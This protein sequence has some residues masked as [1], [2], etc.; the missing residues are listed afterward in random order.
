MQRRNDS[1]QRGYGLGFEIRI[2]LARANLLLEGVWREGRLFFCVIG[3]FIGLSLLNLWSVVPSWLH[4]L[5]LVLFAVAA[6][7]GLYRAVRNF[8]LPDRARALAYL[9]RRNTLAHRP[10]RSLGAR[11]EAEATRDSSSGRLWRLYQR[12]LRR[13]VNG[14]KVGLP[15]LDMGAGDGYGVRALVILLLVA[16][17]IIAGPR[18]GERL[19]AALTPGIG[20]PAAPA[21]VTAWITPPAYTGQAPILLPVTGEDKGTPKTFVVPTNSN[22]IAHIFGGGSGI[23]VLVTDDLR[24]DFIAVDGRNFQ[25][26]TDF[27]SSRNVK[28]EKEGETVANWQ[29]TVIPDEAP[30]V[31]LISEP[32]V[33]ERSAFRLQYRAAD[34]YGVIRIGGEISRENTDEIMDI[35]LP[36]PGRGSKQVVS[37]SYHDLTAHPWAGLPVTLRL[38]AE[39][40][41]GQRGYSDAHNFTLPERTFTHPV[42]KVLIEQRKYLATDAEGNRNNAALVL[43][44]LAGLPESY[45]HDTTVMLSLTAARAILR[46]GTGQKSIDEASDILWET[47]LRLENGSLSLAEAALRA[48]QEALMEALNRDASD[49]EIARLVDEL[50]KAMENFL[51]ALAEQQPMDNQPP[52][53]PNSRDQI[54]RSQDLQQML[55]RIE[56]FARGGAKDAARELLSQLQDMMENLQTA[57][58]QAPSDGQQ[59]QQEMLNELGEMMRRQQELLD[60]T[61]REQQGQRLQPNQPGQPGQ[62]G[63]QPQNGQPGQQPG[64]QGNMQGLA[65]QQEALRRMLGDLMGRLGEQGD[66]PDALGRA[67]RS[68]NEARRALEQGQGR[69]AIEQEGNALENLRQGSQDLAEQIAES[70]EGQ[71]PQQAGQGQPGEGR[72]PLGRSI[73]EEGS[74][75]NVSDSATMRGET[76]AFSKSRDIRNELQRRL[77]DPAR[78]VI[79]KDYLR[80]LL[81]IF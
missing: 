49:E 52:I 75:G 40:Q 17:G 51:S 3:L 58:P 79:E 1:D 29:V 43:D 41:T 44:T 64:Q 71:G 24:Q 47:A 7:Y 36:T 66:I 20:S 35:A 48:A 31:E 73:E 46:N 16:A 34:D 25:I 38:Y 62:Q 22:F 78:P 60:Q 8:R 70:G 10:L 19:Y 23:P 12:S 77:S 27:D 28:I 15:S 11:S 37:K 2:L 45:S 5:S 14:L 50:R 59:A 21:D 65:E 55:D 74:Q 39:D 9:E 63:Q 53:D 61:F 13:H 4:I 80:R 6:I 56:Q 30:T 68:M 72:D 69:P 54:V 32:E 18:A 76:E 33:T 57:R 81:D 67:E 26:E 42:A